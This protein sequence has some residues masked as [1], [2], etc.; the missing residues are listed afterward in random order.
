MKIGNLI[1][2]TLDR[3]AP[4]EKPQTVSSN[5][6]LTNKLLLTEL[7]EHFEAMLE[8][9][10]V[11]ERMLYP[12]NFNILMD[13]SDYE[14]R[15]QSL[16]YILPEVVKAFYGIINKN[17]SEYPNYMP[18]AKNWTFKFSPCPVG[19]LS[20]DGT[21]T[22]T[23]RPGH[24]TTIATLLSFDLN[25]EQNTY[26]DSNTRVSMKLDDSNVMSNMNVNWNALKSL[27]ML[28]EGSFTY[29]FDMSLSRDTRQIESTSNVAELNG[30]A[31]LSYTRSSRNYHFIMKD[32]LIHISG[33]DDKRTGRSIFKLESEDI[34]NSH[35]QI[36]YNQA[37]QKFQ[38]AAFGPTRL[39]S[40][41]LE[42]SNGGSVKWYNLAN[43]SSILINDIGVKFKV[44]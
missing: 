18:P 38:L 4:E 28:G 23:V 16:P 8:E 11:G 44:K 31:E 6:K 33:K 32:N 35:V 13:P 22:M 19:T 37:D 14:A 34:L 21:G 2:K 15:K 24:I 43:N 42:L 7:T 12:M 20:I 3:F 36:R 5:E 29:A 17:K 30:L 39:N 41:E 10:S 25:S 27:D 9:E 26:T 1:K 40:R